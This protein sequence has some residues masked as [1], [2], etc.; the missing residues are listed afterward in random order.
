MAHKETSNF[1]YD[2]RCMDSCPTLWNILRLASY[3]LASASVRQ[4]RNGPYLLG[5]SG[6]K[7]IRTQGG[8]KCL[9]KRKKTK[10]LRSIKEERTIRK[11]TN[12]PQAD[13]V[14]TDNESSPKRAA[15]QSMNLEYHRAAAGAVVFICMVIISHCHLYT[16]HHGK[17]QT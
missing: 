11:R 4:T 5:P 2:G 3:G 12:L 10:R 6:N 13:P 17:G 16:P 9:T 1:F 15:R 7:K 8:K 14:G